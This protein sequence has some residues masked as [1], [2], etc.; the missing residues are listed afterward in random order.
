MKIEFL[1]FKKVWKLSVFTQ[2]FIICLLFFITIIHWY[3]SFKNT[4]LTQW[5]TSPDKT[6]NWFIYF[7]PI[8]EEII[9][10]WLILWVLLKY[11]SPKNS[12]IYSSILF[13]LWHLKNIFYLD[14]TYL[15]YQVFYAIFIIWP[16]LAFI[17]IKTK[18]IW[19]WVI[20]HFLNNFL[21]PISFLVLNF[22]LLSIK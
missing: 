10:R 2:I 6:L 21:S 5:W 12:I 4:W 20:L 16:I 11:N 1:N 13:W 8:Y 18:T 19:I 17:T 22:I 7:A 3:I 15:F 14:L 9:F